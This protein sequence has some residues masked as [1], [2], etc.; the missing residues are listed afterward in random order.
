M[1]ITIVLVAILAL[2]IYLENKSYKYE[3]FENKTIQMPL[4]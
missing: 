2:G 4:W 3:T 1:I